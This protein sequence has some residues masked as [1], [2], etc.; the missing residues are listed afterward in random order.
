VTSRKR[1]WRKKDGEGE[2]GRTFSRVGDFSIK[3]TNMG[4]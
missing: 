1:W 2:E 4:N 3:N